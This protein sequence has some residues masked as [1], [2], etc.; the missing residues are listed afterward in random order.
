MRGKE[1]IIGGDGVTYLYREVL[2]EIYM[3]RS[4]RVGDGNLL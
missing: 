1:E 4:V 3:L 2:G